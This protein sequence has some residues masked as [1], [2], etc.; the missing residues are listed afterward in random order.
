MLDRLLVHVRVKTG[1]KGIDESLIIEK[2]K[3][4]GKA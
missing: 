1:R 2:R 4:L 3:V